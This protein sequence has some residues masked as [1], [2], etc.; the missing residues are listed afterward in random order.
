[1]LCEGGPTLNG[2]LLAEGLVDELFLTVSPLL[3]DGPAPLTIIESTG[4][5]EPVPLELVWMLEEDGML[6]LRYAVA[7]AG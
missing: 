1:M 2:A 7:R 6:F 4:P 5:G 3:A